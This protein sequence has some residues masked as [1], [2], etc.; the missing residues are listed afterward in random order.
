MAIAPM[1]DK[2]I[3][4]VKEIKKVPAGFTSIDALPGTMAHEYIVD[5]TKLEP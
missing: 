3:V 4:V 1:N 2:L 5:V